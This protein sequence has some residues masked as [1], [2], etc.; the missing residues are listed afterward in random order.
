[1]TYPMKNKLHLFI[2][3]TLLSLVL[4][5]TEEV[6]AISFLPTPTDTIVFELDAATYETVDGLTYIDIPVSITSDNNQINAIDYWFQ[7][8]LT[9]LTYVSTSSLFGSLDVFSNFNSTNLYLSNTSSTSFSSVYVPTFE[10]LMILRFQSL[11]PC[12]QITDADFYSI[13]ALLNGIVSSAKFDYNPTLEE[14]SIDSP[15]PHCS[16]Y[17]ESFSFANTYNGSTITDYF[18]DFGDGQNATGQNVLHVYADAGIYPI[19][20]TITTEPG[21]EY[22]ITS[23][24]TIAPSPVSSFTSSYDEVTNVV[25]FTNNS[26]ISGGGV[27][28]DSYWEFGDN[29]TSIEDS[30][31]HTFPNPAFYDVTLT[32]TSDQ[33]CRNSVVISV[34]ATTS[35]SENDLQNR[36]SIYPNPTQGSFYILSIYNYEI[37]INDIT[38]R[39]IEHH[40]SIYAN[41]PETIE[42]QGLAEGIYIIHFFNELH[43][44]SKEIIIEH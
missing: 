44:F 8:D 27:I 33:G 41:R 37:S 24:I 29:T 30:P 3:S 1:M 20:L 21:C 40:R 15:A 28:T 11:N 16:G 9:K 35:I 25:T 6:K 23:E 34:S 42:I 5:P 31:Q 19:T 14:I 32:S 43:S 7:F 22:T 13:N 12:N 39:T 38:G 2:L 4:L 10:P 36:V 26:T 17:D 18:W